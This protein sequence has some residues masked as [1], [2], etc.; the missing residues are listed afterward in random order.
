MRRLGH[1]LT[2]LGAGL[3]VA[4]GAPPEAGLAVVG[5]WL[6]GTAPDW[7]EP[8]LFG[9][10][11]IPH[12]RVTHWLMGWALLL[13]LAIYQGL[14]YLPLGFA[15]GGLTHCLVDLPN[16]MGVPVIHPWRRSSLNWWRSGQYDW[17]ISAL[18]LGAGVACV[19]WPL[20]LGV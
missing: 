15:L 6:G 12:R 10:Q 4:A 1:H 5:G 20:K 14:G 18:F 11:L 13:G 16:P 9:R 8:K 7:L 17:L 19:G 3:I 2:G